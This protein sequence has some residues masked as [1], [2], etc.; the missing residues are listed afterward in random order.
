MV[1]DWGVRRDGAGGME[2]QKIYEIIY[3]SW[4][5]VQVEAVLQG[6]VRAIDKGWYIRSVLE[7]TTS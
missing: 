1:V 4:V 2:G 7:R 5:C 3:V 6:E